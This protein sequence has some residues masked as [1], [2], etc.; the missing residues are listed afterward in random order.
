MF[1]Y[2]F[3]LTSRNEWLQLSVV[4]TVEWV[5]TFSADIIAMATPS[6]VVS[7][8]YLVVPSIPIAVYNVMMASDPLRG[9]KTTHFLKKRNIYRKLWYQNKLAVIQLYCLQLPRPPAVAL[10]I[11]GQKRKAS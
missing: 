9:G 10:T 11:L 1:D 8:V 2:A 6:R 5:V 3:G 7:E 4:E